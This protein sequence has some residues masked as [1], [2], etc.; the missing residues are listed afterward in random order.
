M[1]ERI[2]RNASVVMTGINGERIRQS[3]QPAHGAEHRLRRAESAFA[4][5]QSVPGK[6]CGIAGIPETHRIHGMSG[7]GKTLDK[8]VS[9]RQTFPVFQSAVTGKSGCGGNADR[10]GKE[11]L[12][13]ADPGHM[14]AMRMR[15]Q[16]IAGRIRIPHF[17]NCTAD[18]RSIPARVHDQRVPSANSKIRKVEI[19]SSGHNLHSL[20]HDKI[21]SFPGK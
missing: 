11:A 1:T 13:P 12:H 9:K 2:M 14:V 4:D 19:E 7:R 17:F 10:R 18:Q 8:T 3:A 20:K 16:N 21:L 5:K 15:Q 6:Q